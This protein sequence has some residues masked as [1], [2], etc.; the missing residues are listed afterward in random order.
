MCPERH[1]YVSQECLS[2]HYYCQKLGNNPNVHQLRHK[3]IAIYLYSSGSIEHGR[4]QMFATYSSICE[5]HAHNIEWDNSYLS[6]F[7]VYEKIGKINIW[8]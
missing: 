6:I 8:Y 1:V 3:Q 5:S 2:E 4:K 7:I